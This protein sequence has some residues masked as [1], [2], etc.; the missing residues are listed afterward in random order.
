METVG[1]E[2]RKLAISRRGCE[3][4]DLFARSAFNR[5]YYSAFLKT[6]STLKI[7]NPSWGK[8]KHANLPE[9]L[10]GKVI[11]LVKA[12][13]KKQVAQGLITIGHKSHKIN[14]LTT[15]TTELAN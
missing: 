14:S 4:K 3:E 2:L 15:A 10:E 13:L 12:E 1:F 9:L 6:R 8:S 11:S 7:L 5:F